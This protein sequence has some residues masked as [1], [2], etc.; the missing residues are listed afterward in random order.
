[1]RF[2]VSCMAIILIACPVA[3]HELSVYT[4]IINSEGVYPA[5]IPDDSLKEGDDAWFWMKDSTNNTTVV[6]ELEWNGASVRSPHLHYECDLDENGT[7]VDESCSTRYD[8]TFNQQNSAG[9]W[10]ITV[11]KYIDGE[12]KEEISGSVCIEEDNHEGEAI[13]V[14]C[15]PPEAVDSA[16]DEYSTKKIVAASVAIFAALGLFV[17]LST[18]KG[19]ENQLTQ[20]S[21]NTPH[22][23]TADVVSEEE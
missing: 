9:L 16:T 13:D 23:S 20:D 6:V 12:L 19:E 14:V 5:H 4:V 2:L 18:I 1:M 21:H 8:H 17:T 22:S 15:V 7:L 11:L 3:G 10:N